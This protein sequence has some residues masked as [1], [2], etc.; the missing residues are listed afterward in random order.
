MGKRS[1][2]MRPRRRSSSIR[3]GSGAPRGHRTSRSAIFSRVGDAISSPTGEPKLLDVWQLLIQL[4]ATLAERDT[5][6][7]LI[8]H[9]R[10]WLDTHRE[11]REKC[12]SYLDCASGLYR[13]TS[14]R[15][16]IVCDESPDLAQATIDALLS[17]DVLQVSI[18][19]AEGVSASKAV[20][21]PL[22]PLNLWRYLRLSEIM[23]S[24]SQLGELA[25]EDRKVLIEELKRPETFLSVS[26]GRVRF[27][28]DAVSISFY[29]LPTISR[30]WRPS[31]I[32]TTPS[33][34]QTEW[35][36]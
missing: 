23:R 1:R 32:C 4:R 19:G 36:R 8:V 18:S 25:P 3:P 7:P 14:Q 24:L 12:Q 27:R 28:K 13:L 21:L 17:I 6:R 15:F 9:P 20:M 26:S 22:H 35:R 31:R 16:R 2:N 11:T 33:V 10:E 29:P 5:L 34:A 30:D